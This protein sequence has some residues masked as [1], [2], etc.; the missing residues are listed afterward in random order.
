MPDQLKK[1]E[2]AFELGKLYCDRGDF[3]RAIDQLKESSE[4]FLSLKDWGQ[5]LKSQNLLLRLYAETE[6]QEA[7]ES[8][9]NSLHDLVL[10]SG[11]ELNAK[12]HYTLGLCAS[13]RGQDDVALEYLQKSLSLALSS[14]NKEDLCYA[15]SGLALVYAGLKRYDD[16]LKEIYNLEIFFEVISLPEVKVAAQLLNAWILREKGKFDQAVEILWQAYETV[17]THK[18]MTGHLAILFSLG[19]A[20]QKSG[21]QDLAALYLNL[22]WKLVDPSNMIRM[23]SQIQSAMAELGISDKKDFDLVFDLEKHSVVEKRLGKVD[24]KNQ[25][26]LM[27]LLRLFVQ[28]QGKVY[29]KEDLVETVW[30]QKYEPD[31]HDNKIYVTIKRL[32]KMIEPDFDRPK[33]IFRAK[34][35]YFMN[36]AAKVLIDGERRGH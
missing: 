18:T 25:F 4:A 3:F 8:T 26:I 7:I 24:F 10:R 27:D 22:A 20:Y 17:R 29:S 11:L 19:R 2:T 12:T 30:K 13:Y 31:V 1:A 35:G 36:S 34:N 14:D 6:Q 23:A 33:Y 21:Q 9:K 15:I 32:R 16:A 5:Y 28:N